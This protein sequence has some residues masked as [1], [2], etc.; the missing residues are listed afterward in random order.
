MN[1][2]NRELKPESR[3]PKHPGLFS[4]R[5]AKDTLAA[6]LFLAPALVAFLLFFGL[7]IL[8]TVGLCFAKYDLITPMRFTGWENFHQ[9]LGDPQN[10]TVFKNTFKFLLVLVPA[11]VVVGLLL[12]LSVSRK[13]SKGLKYLYRSAIYFPTVVTTASVAIL[14]GYLYSTNFGALNYLL[15]LIGIPTVPWLSSVHWV[16]PTVM[17]F[18]L[19]KFVGNSFMFYFIGLQNVPES[20]Y[21][22]AEIDGANKMQVF[23]KVTLPMLSPTIFFVLI[24]NCLNV[25]QIFDEPY[26]LTKGGPGDASLTVVLHLFRKAFQSYE[27]GYASLYALALFVIGLVLTALQFGL[28]KKWVNYDYE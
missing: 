21:E 15:G 25:I 19:W 14:W 3:E 1:S 10:G 27:I 24:Y 16:I 28:Q 26:F 12:A 7:P 9:F 17:I 13:I 8:I 5:R 4:Q 23:W 6:Y 20:F 2:N 22:A 11:H 18:S